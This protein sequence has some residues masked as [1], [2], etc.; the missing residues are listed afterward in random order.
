MVRLYGSER[1]RRRRALWSI[2]KTLL[3]L[4][5]MGGVAASVFYQGLLY[6]ERTRETLAADADRLKGDLVSAQDRINALEGDIAEVQADLEDWRA[7]YKSD[8][9]QGDALA[10]YGL[11][12]ERLEAGVPGERIGFLLNSAQRERV[13]DSTLVTARFGVQ[14]PG[15]DGLTR[16]VAFGR[17]RV[18]VSVTGQPLEPLG[19]GPVIYDPDKPITLSV[20]DISGQAVEEIGILPLRAAIVAGDS[21][22]RFLVE[23][24]TSGL[25]SVTAERCEYP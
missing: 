23:P 11:L 14:I 24:E 1:R 7:R 8:V 25:V 16:P 3:F 22:Y 20:A 18:R 12:R 9:P 6:G 10:L 21:E 15:Q 13:C 17:G 5:F 4:G 2:V 19:G